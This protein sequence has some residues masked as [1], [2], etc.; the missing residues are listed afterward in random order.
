MG[1]LYTEQPHYLIQNEPSEFF[2]AR[3]RLLFEMEMD[4][5]TIATTQ[6][7]YIL[8]ALE[9]AQGHHSRGK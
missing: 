5:P 1:A 9:A 2:A 3:T 4:C 6:A 8:S 7:A